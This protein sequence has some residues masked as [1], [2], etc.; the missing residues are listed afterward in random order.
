MKKAIL[1]L[2]AV[3]M[4][5][6]TAFSQGSGDPFGKGA[7]AINFGIGFGNTIY[8][9]YSMAWPS[10][11][12]SYEYGIVEIGMGSSMKGIISVGGLAGFGGAKNNYGWGEV[13]SNYFLVAVRGNY[14][15]IFHDKFDPYA[16]IIT[17]YYFGN[18]KYDYY[19]GYSNWKYNENSNGFHVGAYA[20][21]RWFFTPAFAVFSELGWNISIFTVGVTLKF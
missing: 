17:G 16:G 3:A 5:S 9:G 13:S 8:G 4:L 21:V 20:G 6:G 7:S 15:F 10:F 12:V 18:Y 1:L 11:S 14:H 19:P 2:A